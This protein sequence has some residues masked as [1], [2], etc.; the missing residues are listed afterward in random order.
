VAADDNQPDSKEGRIKRLYDRLAAIVR[1]LPPERAEA[2]R[3]HL[4]E[5]QG[6]QHGQNDPSQTPARDTD[7]P[8]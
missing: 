1:G 3:E 5:Q 6:D 2:F 4:S 7:D 8:D